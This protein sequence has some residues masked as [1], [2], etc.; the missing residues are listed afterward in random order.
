MQSTGVSVSGRGGAILSSGLVLLIAAGFLVYGAALRHGPRDGGLV[1][2][3]AFNSANGLKP[4]ANVDLAG[5]PVG[6][7]LGITLDPRTQMADVA[8]SVDRRLK[9]PIDT[10]VGIGAPSMT[11]DNALQIEP[12]KA[13]QV[14]G[15]GGHITDSRDQLSLEQQVS[16]YIFGG[17]KLGQ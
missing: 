13:G 9:L 8:F 4:G 6:R 3:A 10:A 1:L 7:V 2:H 12:G 5:V 11:A 16:N 14:L 17:G 15:S